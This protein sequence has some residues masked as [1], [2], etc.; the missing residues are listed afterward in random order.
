MPYQSRDA[1][2]EKLE[3]PPPNMHRLVAVD[4]ETGKVV[5][6]I[7]L[8]LQKGRRA[9]AAGISMM[10]LDDYQSQGIGSKLMEGVLDLAENWLNLK[11][12]ELT[13]YTDNEPAI[14]LYKKYG[15]AIEGTFH[16]YA[17]RE[18]SY[19]DAHAMAKVIGA[20]NLVLI[21]VEADRQRLQAYK[22]L[23]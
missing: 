5:G 8:H 22:T 6:M 20:I 4:D 12:I 13:V 2:K 18:G 15:F 19:V 14:H 23:N 1:I 11:R 16:N 10:M 21:L 9:H 7:G 17:L 3:N